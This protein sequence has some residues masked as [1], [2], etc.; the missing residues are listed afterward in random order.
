[1]YNFVDNANFQNCLSG[2]VPHAGSSFKFDQLK[3]FLS[4]DLTNT[5]RWHGVNITSFLTIDQQLP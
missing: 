2:P 4:M 1:M 3:Q 5:Q